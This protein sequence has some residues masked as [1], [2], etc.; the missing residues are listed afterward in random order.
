MMPIRRNW[1]NSKRQ[2]EGLVVGQGM[3]QS[4]HD[5]GLRL[6]GPSSSY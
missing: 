4:N 5:L 3:F 1:R 6:I 2:V